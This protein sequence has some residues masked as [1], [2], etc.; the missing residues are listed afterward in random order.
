MGSERVF[1]KGYT[2]KEGK[3]PKYK[4]LE[5]T[6]GTSGKASGDTYIRTHPARQRLTAQVL[7]RPL[8]K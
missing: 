4:A 1:Y 8:G 5:P 3:G 6:P 7:Q 2:E